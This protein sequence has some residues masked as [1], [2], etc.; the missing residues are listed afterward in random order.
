MSITVTTAQDLLVNQLRSAFQDEILTPEKIIG[1]VLESLHDY[2]D[3]TALGY[4]DLREV[5]A[6]EVC[7]DDAFG[8]A[9]RI[10]KANSG[11]GRR[12]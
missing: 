6:L 12:K 4:C 2:D 3:W 8:V 7:L 10:E 11:G 9:H 1:A 5:E